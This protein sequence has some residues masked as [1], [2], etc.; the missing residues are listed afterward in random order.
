[1][2]TRKQVLLMS[3]LLLVVLM[4]LGVYAA[5]YPYRATDAATEFDES[6]AE[7]GAIIFARN[8]RLCHGDVAEGGALGARLP[9]AP[10]LHR[11]DLQGFSDTGATLANDIDAKTT[12]FAVKNPEKLKKGNILIEDEWMSLNKIDGNNLTVSRGGDHSGSSPHSADAAVLLQDPDLLKQKVSLIT[13]TITCG[14]VGTPMPAWGNSQ[15]GPLSDEQIRQ[16]MTVITENRWDLVKAEDDV[17]DKLATHLT[18][19]MDDSTISMHVDDVTV[20]NA[21]DAIRI[22]DERLR[23]DA[24]PTLPKDAKGK[25]P[26]NKSGIV[27]VERGV[28]GT[29]PLSHETSEVIY[30]FPEVAS[31]A[32]NMASCGQTAQ[33]PAPAGK[34]SLVEPFTGQ[35][36]NVKASNISYDTKNITVKT[37]GDVRVRLDNE[38]NGTEHN[39]A[40]YK[41]KTDITPVASG[42]VGLHFAGVAQNDTVFT[43]PAAGTYYFRC[44][45]HPTIME[46]TFT[47]TN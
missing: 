22:G 21:K 39:I 17:E 26:K 18:E 38:D 19:A 35:T 25:L 15:G 11:G 28:L 3:G 10:P 37:G 29:T 46:G 30:H 41:S 44:D 12:T 13:N 42:S 1:M 16:L 43:I 20:F 4:V 27:Q 6:T 32:I 2:N 31:P 45:V 47:V 9:A 24:V 5:W 33:A 36:V 40:F 23:V 8:C 14:R 7:R 34:P